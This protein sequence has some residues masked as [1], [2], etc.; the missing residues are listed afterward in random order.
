MKTVDMIQPYG[1]IIPMI[2]AYTTPGVSY[3]EGWTKIGYTEKQTVKDRIRQQ[4]HTADIQVKLLWRDNAIYKDGS[5]ESFTDHDFH[6]YLERY[7]GVDRQP[8]TEWFHID[9]KKSKDYF[10][11]FAQRNFKVDVE[12]GLSYVL[13][14]E[15][16]EAVEKTKA[17]F[18]KGGR[19]FLWNAKP[20]FGKTLTSYDLIRTMG[21][22]NTLVVTNRP[23]IANSWAEDFQKFIAWQT[24]LDFVSDTDALKGK[25]GVMTRDEFLD[26]MGH[27]EEHHQGMVA[28][29]SLQGLKGS[30]YFGGGIDKLKWIS[31]LHFDLLIVDE[32][33]EGAMLFS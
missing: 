27:D 30:V 4:T 14:R 16:R 25:K 11:E 31:D 9:G 7:K 15:Q 24:P 22:R 28:F 32:S 29:E 3:H 1:R 12:K 2:Y 6:E 5:G 8:K 26:A 19:E 17:Y 20:R 23:S 33:Q 18:E 13:R 21:F 10:D